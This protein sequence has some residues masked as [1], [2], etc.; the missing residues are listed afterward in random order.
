[1]YFRQFWQDKRLEFERRPNLEN[2]VVGAEYINQ[3]WT[4]DTFFVNEKTAYFHV[5]TTENQFLRILHD[6]K[7]LRSI[8]WVPRCPISFHV[9]LRAACIST[10][11]SMKEPS[12]MFRCLVA[13][14]PLHHN[15]PSSGW[16]RL[17]VPPW[18]TLSL[19]LSPQN[20]CFGCCRQIRATPTHIHIVNET[21]SFSRLTITASCPMDLQY[22]PMD[23]Q[24]CYI[25]IESCKLIT[26]TKIH[27]NM[28][29][30]Q[31]G[32]RWVIF[33][34][35]GTMGSTQFRCPETC[36]CHSLR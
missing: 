29:W 16:L 30:F 9:S 31:L 11:L 26:I 27:S 35:S 19:P 4:P 12:L 13:T 15:F 20:D 22:F 17:S 25:E 21:I 33:G 2:L 5:A 32:T 1:M 14:T 23:S 6:G 36:P 8:R 18:D 7:V 3:I 10:S 24:L 28:L 34:T